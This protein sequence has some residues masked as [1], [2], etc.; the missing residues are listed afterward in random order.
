[1]LLPTHL[2]PFCPSEIAKRL[3]LDGNCLFREKLLRHF[4][5]PFLGQPP[6]L[7]N[8]GT[9]DNSREPPLCAMYGVFLTELKSAIAVGILFPVELFIQSIWVADGL[10]EI[11]WV[12]HSA[13]K[14]PAK[15]DYAVSTW[16][17]FLGLHKCDLSP[18]GSWV[19]SSVPRATV[20]R[21]V[22][23]IKG[24]NPGGGSHGGATISRECFKFWVTSLVT[25]RAGCHKTR[26]PF[27]LWPVQTCPLA[28]LLLCYLV[29]QVE[30]HTRRWSGIDAILLDFR[31]LSQNKYH[32]FLTYPAS[33]KMS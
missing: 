7:L 4:S 31:A 24:W 17:R 18:K 23:I 21:S 12:L 27:M 25:M 13:G 22:E 6:C 28:L 30:V 26:L 10:S 20:L 2:C 3:E 33:G 14:D 1:M 29:T 15:G 11:F 32:F 9:W 5:F 16:L 19:G 8:F